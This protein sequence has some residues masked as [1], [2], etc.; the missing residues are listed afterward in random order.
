MRTFIVRTQDKEDDDVLASIQGREI[1]IANY[2]L[3]ADNYADMLAAPNIVAL[4][5]EWPPEF[6][7]FKRATAEQVATADLSAAD[8]DRLSLL[9]FRNYLRMLALTTAIERDKAL[10]VYAALLK[11][12]PAGTR[13]DAA[14]LRMKAKL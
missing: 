6:A 2:D 8:K 7:Q 9:L 1:E 5:D 4:P 13:R 3:N 12:L 10:S 11:R 14:I